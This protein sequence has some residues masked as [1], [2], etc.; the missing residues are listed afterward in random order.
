MRLFLAILFEEPVKDR[1]LRGDGADPA[2]HLD[3]VSSPG[4]RIFI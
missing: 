2:E 1:L 4:G 3:K